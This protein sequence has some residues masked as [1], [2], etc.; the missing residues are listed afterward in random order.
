MR[1]ELKTPG[2]LSTATPMP[3]SVVPN[4]L[5]SSGDAGLAVK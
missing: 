1:L 2:A 4:S 5:R 3:A